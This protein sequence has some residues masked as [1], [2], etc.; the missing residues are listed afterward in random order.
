MDWNT[1]IEIFACLGVGLLA[2]ILLGWTWRGE[3]LR[4]DMPEYWRWKLEVK[5][6]KHPWADVP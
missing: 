6:Y 4:R 2:G 3:I 1:L 5:D